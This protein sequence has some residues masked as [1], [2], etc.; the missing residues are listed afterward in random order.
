VIDRAVADPDAPDLGVRA[1]R[2]QV[3]ASREGIFRYLVGAGIDVKGNDL[4]SVPG[5]YLRAHQAL[6]GVL[7]TSRVL[8][9][10][11]ARLPSGHGF[12]SIRRWRRLLSLYVNSR[13]PK[14]P[15]RITS[16]QPKYAPVRADV[17]DGRDVPRPK[18]DERLA[19]Q[20]V[21]A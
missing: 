17:A 18:Q 12:S 6:I 7:A 15:D 8:F 19:G 14:P 10:A 11:V 13:G 2:Q 9:F 21:T 20:S 16:F 1:T 5:F 4:P 3:L